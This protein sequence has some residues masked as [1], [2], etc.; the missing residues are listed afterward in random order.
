MNFDPKHDSRRWI[1]YFDLLGI[2]QA[3]RNNAHLRVF[4]AYQQAIERLEKLG[5]DHSRI[6]YTWFSDTFVF[7]TA[8]DSGTSFTEIEQVSRWFVY[9]LITA[10]IP[11]RGAIACGPMY[12]DFDNHVFIGTA[13]VEAYHYGEAQDWIGY[14][15][16]PSAAETMRQLGIPPEERVHYALWTPQWSKNPPANSPEKLSACLLGSWITING[17]NPVR[18]KLQEIAARHEPNSN[19]RSKYERAIQFLDE[20]PRHFGDNNSK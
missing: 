9:F 1:A 7:A 16:C 8:D 6:R 17:Q 19:I 3:I 13:F 15:L 11:L 20:N 12:A 10:G 5:Q 14:T 18:T 2:K 4:I